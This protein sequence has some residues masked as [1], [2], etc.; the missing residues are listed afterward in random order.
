MV[1]RKAL[2]KTGVTAIG[3]AIGQWASEWPKH[4]T[5]NVTGMHRLYLKYNVDDAE[6]EN[7]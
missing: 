2:C 6:M 4:F 7:V 5:G 1:F 3:Q